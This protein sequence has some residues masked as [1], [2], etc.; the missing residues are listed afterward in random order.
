M[1]I[2]QPSENR[3]MIGLIIFLSSDVWPNVTSIPIPHMQTEDLALTSQLK[4][5]L[6]VS[7][8]KLVFREIQFSKWS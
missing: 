2:A 8:L 3:I 1:M 7:M 6:Q 5:L 4:S